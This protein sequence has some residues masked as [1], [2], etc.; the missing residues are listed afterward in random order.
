MTSY[1][2]N[3]ELL[4]RD[5]IDSVEMLKSELDLITHN[6]NLHNTLIARI[7]AK[8]EPML[9]LNYDDPARKLLD[10]ALAN[11][12]IETLKAEA[13]VI[14]KQEGREADIERIRKL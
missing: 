7:I 5:L 8:L 10:K 9:A 4:R 11:Q 13:M 12:V 6:I 1:T 3:L 2:K 14:A